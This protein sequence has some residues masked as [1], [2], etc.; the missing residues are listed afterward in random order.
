M[1]WTEGASGN[2]EGRPKHVKPWKEAILRAIKRREESD[3]H[4]LDKLADKLL[5]KVGEGDVS[6]IKEF[7]DRLDGKVPQGIGGSDE[8]PALSVI[9]AIEIVAAA[10]DPKD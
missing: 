2:P 1:A 3:P 8:L 5:D 7:G 9:T 4:A 6:A 10:H